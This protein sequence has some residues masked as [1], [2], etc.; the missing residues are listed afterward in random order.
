METALKIVE[1]G[2]EA[3][4]SDEY[5]SL[6]EKLL[7]EASERRKGASVPERTAQDIIRA[8]LAVMERITTNGGE[9]PGLSTGLQ[10]LDRMTTG[11]QPSDLII[12]AG[13]PATGKSTLAQN[14]A[15]H[16]A[17]RCAVPVGIF[18]LE[19]SAEQIGNRMLSSESGT[20]HDKIRTASLARN[21]L[22]RIGEAA[23]RLYDAP[24]WID[25]AGELSI[26]ELAARARRM[27]QRYGIGLII[28]DY[29]QLAKGKS[30]KNNREQEVSS[31][32]RG[33]KALAKELDIPIIALSQLNRSAEYEKRRI[34]LSDLR[35]SGS[36]E[37]DADVV[38]F[39]EN[40]SEENEHQDIV[41]K[42]LVVAKQRSGPTGAIVLTFVKSQ[43]TFR[44]YSA[45]EEG[46]R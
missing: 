12:I 39:L 30:E 11:L 16:A 33:L 35:E 41:K 20:D 2:Y 7:L 9:M 28:V 43:L 10:D 46:T 19:M 45:R 44:C 29:L 31:I 4:D 40:D 21:D 26:T 23:A 15:Q 22:E 17:L 3:E 8:N 24:L 27:K 37:Q 18:S 13:R 32:S 5:I 1:M 38:M 6:A 34:R 42:E 25:D 36:I 14:I